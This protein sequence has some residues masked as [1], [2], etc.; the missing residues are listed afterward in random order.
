MVR[1]RG[2]FNSVGQTCYLSPSSMPGWTLVDTHPTQGR[3]FQRPLE[4]MEECSY[5]YQRFLNGTSDILHH[6]EIH[7]GSSQDAHLFS[8]TN[9]VNAWLS[10]K[11]RYPLVGATVRNAD[12]TPFQFKVPADG[13]GFISQPHFVIQEHDLAILRPGEITFGSVASAEEAHRHAAAIVHGEYLLSDDLQVQ[14]HVLR[15]TDPEGTGVLHL[16]MYI[17]HCLADEIAI[18]TLLRCLLDTLAR[19]REFEPAQ[20][21]LE[22]RLAM[23][24]PMMELDPAHLRSLS[25]GIRRWRKAVGAVIFQLRLAKTQVSAVFLAL[26]TTGL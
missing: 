14:L 2:R 4:P 6:C 17:S 3:T 1:F 7:T 22:D 18:R 19:S 9:I 11:R 8:E 23:A 21:P 16:M 10:M 24:V 5:L 13:A 25:P 20:L 15:E 26:Y 12:R